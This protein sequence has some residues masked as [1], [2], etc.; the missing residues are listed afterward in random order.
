[1]AESV[2]KSVGQVSLSIEV[3][4]SPAQAGAEIGVS[5]RVTCSPACDTT[6]LVVALFEAGGNRLGEVELSRFD[7]DAASSDDLVLSAPLAVGAHQWTAVLP[8]FDAGDMSFA[9]ATVPIDIEVTAHAVTLNIWGLPGAI[10]A[11]STASMFVGARCSCGCAL[12]GRTI[13]IHD[14]TGALIS[15]AVLGDTV[16]QKTEALYFAEAA[17]SVAGGEGMHDWQVRFAGAD[18][19]PEHASGM[20]PVGVRIVAPAEHVVTVEAVDDNEAPLAGAI[21]SMHPFRT[22]TDERG[23]AQIHVPK[24]SYRLF[25]SARRH[26]SSHTEIDVSGD[27]STR[28]RLAVEIR[29]ER[30]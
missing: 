6:G 13:T 8:G 4:S 24:G 29:P 2:E 9:G 16:W 3:T 7:G 30:L 19:T 11:G 20:A 23:V 22:T 27:V 18:M 17:F 10:A 5:A 26:V 1:V 14:E 21:V 15:E 25:V 28:A 12:G